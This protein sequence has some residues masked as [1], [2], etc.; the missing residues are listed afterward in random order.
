MPVE[1][2]F[3]ADIRDH[4]DDDTPRLIYA[5]WLEEQGDVRCEFLRL[6]IRLAGMEPR[7]RESRRLRARLRKLRSEIDANWLALLDRAPVEACTFRM[8]FQCSQ[9]W[10]NLK[11]TEDS[12]VR[13]CD[14]CNQKVYHCGSLSEAQD[15]ARRRHCVA[16]DS[17]LARSPGDLPVFPLMMT[18]GRAEVPSPQVIAELLRQRLQQQSESEGGAEPRPPRRERRRKRR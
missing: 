15:H 16:V 4:P 11:T 12:R 8:Q 3:L 17:R 18:L 10:E 13:F 7:S 2:A 9:R 5:D 1:D 6:E 14:S